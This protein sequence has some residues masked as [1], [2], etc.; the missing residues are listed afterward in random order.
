MPAPKGFS[1]KN[2]QNVWRTALLNALRV[3]EK[4]GVCVAGGALAKIAM[5]V[6]DMA[7]AES[8][9]DAIQEVANRL[10]GKPAQSLSVETTGDGRPLRSLTDEELEAIAAIA[11]V[12][13]TGTIESPSGEI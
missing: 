9:W 6:V 7:A 8:K 1:Q 11:A 12:G 10:D 3:Y 5:N 13:S 2:R 4:E